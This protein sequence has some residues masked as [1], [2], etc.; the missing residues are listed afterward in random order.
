MNK[1]IFNIGDLVDCRVYG[2]GEVTGIQGSSNDFKVEVSFEREGKKPFIITYLF[3]GRVSKDSEICL[4]K[5]RWVITEEFTESGIKYG[6]PV[7]YSNNGIKWF[8]GF[9]VGMDSNKFVVTTDV[10]LTGPTN[11]FKYCKPLN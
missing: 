6:E 11:S 7:L 4:T 2:S 8:I 10:D 3:D 1:N 9:F 5:G